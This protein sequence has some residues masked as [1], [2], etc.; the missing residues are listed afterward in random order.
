MK[1]NKI[2]LG[3]PLFCNLFNTDYAYMTGAMANGIASEELVISLGKS[4]I[5]A[6]F[7]AAGLSLDRIQLAINRIKS[8]LTNKPFCFNLIYHPDACHTEFSIVELY[9]KNSIHVIEAS[10]FMKI[11]R[12]LVF[13]KVSGLTVNLNN[14]KIIA[15]VSHPTIAEQ[16]MQPAPDEMLEE[17]LHSEIITEQQADLAKKVPLADAITIEA[18]SGGHT[19]NQSLLCLFPIFKKMRNDIEK[20]YR[21]TQPLLMGAAGG[22][23]TPSA[24]AA[25]FM[26][27]ADYVVTGSINQSTVEAGTSQ[28]VKKLLSEVKVND[29]E[30]APAPDMFEIG[31]KVQ[32]SKRG[33]LFAMRAKKLYDI[34]QSYPSIES[35]PSN[36]IDE[37]EKTIFRQ[38]ISDVWKKTYDYL[39]HENP[40]SIDQ[41]E[42]NPKKKL[43]AIFKWYMGLSSKWAIS[44][45]EER[46][47]DYQI[48]CGPAM[49]SFN[50][51]AEYTEF[52]DIKNRFVVKIALRLLVEAEQ[53]FKM[54]INNS[55]SNPETELKIYNED[56][57][58]HWLCQQIANELSI[59]RK[60]VDI[61]TPFI[62]FQIDS[63]KSI[64]IL[65]KLEKLINIKL[66]PTL[67]W[68]YPTIESLSKKIISL[69]HLKEEIHG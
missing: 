2:H 65:N 38:S 25:A 27:G 9:L 66:S 3:N 28:K 32:V 54:H 36:I 57:L 12:S 15:K 30:M 59:N 31:A 10:A 67:I 7:G 19:D 61:R 16:F 55:I 47:I 13:F 26:L 17:L 69:L 5:L 42:L 18:D 24:I 37:L 1:L 21:Y 64:L 34:Y 39:A 44:G 60:E 45:L 4:N 14:H 62:E 68:S 33:T 51:W 8:T 53:Y 43:A 6:S 58:K 56:T 40:K 11:T 48:W 23:G 63:I 22:I 41:I 52:A 35:I 20:K 46:C 50:S 49:G 29:C